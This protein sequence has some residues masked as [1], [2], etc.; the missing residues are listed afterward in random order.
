MESRQAD[1]LKVYQASIRAKLEDGCQIYASATK[2]ALK[3]LDSIH[4]QF[5]R[6]SPGA[7]RSSPVVSLY[8]KMDDRVGYAVALSDTTSAKR[9][10]QFAV[11]YCQN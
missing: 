2:T 3:M 11:I 1:S 8:A 10:S 5:I 4:R 7:F 9:A 6:L